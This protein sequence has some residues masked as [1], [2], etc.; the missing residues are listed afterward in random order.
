MSIVL[1]GTT[2]ITT[3]DVTSDG[4]LKIDASAPDDSLVVD[5]SGNVGVGVTPS[6]WSA[7]IKAID[8]N[9]T[10]FIYGSG[11]S[12]TIGENGHYDG[13][14]WRYKTTS[15]ATYYANIAGQHRWYIAPSGTAGDA[16]TWTQAMTLNASGQLG[17][18]TA[19]PSYTLDVDGTTNA[20]TYR[21]NGVAGK[22]LV[23]SDIVSDGTNYSNTGFTNT[24]MSD[25]LAFTPASASSEVWVSIQ[26]FVSL[27][28]TGGDNDAVGTLYAYTVQ[29]NG[30]T[31]VSNIGLATGTTDNYIG[32]FDLAANGQVRHCVS[33]EGPATRSSD[34]AVRVRL[35]GSLGSDATA[36]YAATMTMAVCTATFKEYL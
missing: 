19:S 32:F 8:I 4:A 28:Q 35:Y 11:A 23:K 34:G 17:I 31:I 3:P 29:S 14:A 7:S 2:G 10:G 24:F 25:T 5:A 26:A 22:L 12:L 33:I 13:T 16:I 30:T 27:N 20:T 6:A 18:N 36:N 9:T 15:E 1:N 21:K